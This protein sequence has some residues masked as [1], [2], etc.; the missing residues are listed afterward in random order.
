MPIKLVLLILGDV[1][2]FF[3]YIF[4]H[5]FG[6]LTYNSCREITLIITFIE[7][8]KTIVEEAFPRDST[9]IPS[10]KIRHL[11]KSLYTL[12]M[13]DLLLFINLYK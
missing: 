1:F 10:G 11:P 6:Q 7:I 9:N 8:F 5:R 2:L 12:I 13:N 4:S 3:S